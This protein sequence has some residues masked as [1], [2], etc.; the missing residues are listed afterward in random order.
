VGDVAFLA[1]HPSARER[2]S[3]STSS[4]ED[5]DGGAS[6]SQP[7]HYDRDAL[8]GA[9]CHDL[10]APLAAVMMGANFVLQTTPVTD[11]TS[12][13][14][15]VL[16]AMLRSCKQMERLIRD[17][18]DLA[19]IDSGSVVLRYGMSDP[20]QLLEMAAEVARP[21]AAPRHVTIEV[22]RAGAPML[23]RCDRER[24]L[25]AIG[26]LLDNAVRVSPEGTSI[27]L[28]A[29]EEGSFVRLR[30]TDQGPGLSEETLANLY[31]RRWHAARA[32]RAGAGLGLAIARGVITA[33][34]GSI[35]VL[36]SPGT[37]TTFSLLL[38][39]DS[40]ATS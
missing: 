15:R 24:I 18:G 21:N 2:K 9:I 31:D 27:T 35:E 22:V 23:I 6:S 26:H 13:S 39:K 3:S 32:G 17:F 33:H 28:R 30:V 36:S 38:P 37:P 10:R 11:A 25:R 40:E 1:M 12:R 16:D 20:E 14:R 7:A 29:D 34:G 19:E 4:T 8:L 5:G